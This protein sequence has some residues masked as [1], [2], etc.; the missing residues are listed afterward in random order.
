MAKHIKVYFS[1]MTG[2]PEFDGVSLVFL[3][4]DVTLA[5]DSVSSIF[6]RVLIFVLILV[7]SRS[8]DGCFKSRCHTH[9]LG[10]KKED[11]EEDQIFHHELLPFYLEIKTLFSTLH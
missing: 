6:L 3:S 5:V 10:R 2:C 9:S 7:T 11:E 1:H 8:Q 4:K